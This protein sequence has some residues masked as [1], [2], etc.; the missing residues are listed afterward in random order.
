MLRPDNFN[1][2]VQ[3]GVLDAICNF[4]ISVNTVRQDE[5]WSLRVSYLASRFQRRVRRKPPRGR[6]PDDAFHRSRRRRGPAD[7]RWAAQVAHRHEP[8][9]PLGHRHHGRARE[10][11]LASRLRPHPIQGASNQIGPDPVPTPDQGGIPVQGSATPRPDP[12]R[13]RTEVACGNHA[14]GARAAPG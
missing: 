1:R 10:G 3:F 9:R 7:Q 4:D 2:R 14:N 12:R 5:E 6:R 11:K 13:L 8:L